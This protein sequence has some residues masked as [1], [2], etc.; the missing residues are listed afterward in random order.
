ML[1]TLFFFSW[2]TEFLMPLFPYTSVVLF[3]LRP[4]KTQT[5][6]KQKSAFRIYSPFQSSFSS[7]A[8]GSIEETVQ[9]L[10]MWSQGS[11]VLK[12]NL[13]FDDHSKQSCWL[14]SFSAC[15]M[16]V[17]L[18]PL[19]SEQFQLDPQIQVPSKSKYLDTLWFQWNIWL[20]INRLGIQS[21]PTTEDNTSSYPPSFIFP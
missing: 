10:W 6:V 3:N 15:C 9:K 13:R 2:R 18:L 19:F 8:D 20:R 4:I 12:N 1:F 7:T 17:G 11:D 21:L 14:K 16:Y 5:W